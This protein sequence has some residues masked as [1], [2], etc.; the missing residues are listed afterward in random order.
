MIKLIALLSKRQ[1][2]T[3]REFRDTYEGQ[4]APL[5]VDHIPFFAGYRRSYL[6]RPLHAFEA[7]EAGKEAFPFHAITEMWYDDERAIAQQISAIDGAAGDI[8]ARD[9][10]TLF[11]RSRLAMFSADERIT[12]SSALCPPAEGHGDFPGIKISGLLRKKNGLSFDDFQCYCEERHAALAVDLLRLNGRSLLAAY[13][14]SYP[15][16]DQTY[17]IGEQ[18]GLRINFDVITDLWFWTDE[19]A[20]TAMELLRHPDIGARIVQDEEAFLDRSAT[21]IYVV[22]ERETNPNEISASLARLER[23]ARPLQN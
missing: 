2:L 21:R 6:V 5:I 19:D 23:L 22:A 3:D 1:A 8:I 4:H 13:A 11:D 9:E 20:R 7:Q 10:A 16:P 14:R 18:P 17:P 15:L 12:D